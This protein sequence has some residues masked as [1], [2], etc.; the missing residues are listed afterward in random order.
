MKKKVAVALLSG[1]YETEYS[2]LKW[3]FSNT[4]ENE[5]EKCFSQNLYIKDNWSFRFFSIEIYKIQLPGVVL[6]NQTVK[7]MRNFFTTLK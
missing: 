5:A 7:D 2:T 3:F 1:I 6:F 4:Q